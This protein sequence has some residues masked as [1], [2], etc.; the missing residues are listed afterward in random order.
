MGNQFLKYLLCFFTGIFYCLEIAAQELFPYAEAAS[1]L[2]KGVFSYR[3]STEYYKDLQNHSKNWYAVRAMYG[4]TKNF[5]AILTASGSN[6][7]IKNFPNGYAAYFL[8]HHTR[9][10]SLNAF[11]F[12]GF[13]LYLKYRVVHL[14]GYK[15]H[16]RLAVY[17]EGSNCRVAHD[18]A[19]PNLMGDNAGFG[20][21]AIA[22]ALYHRAALSITAGYVKP[23]GYYDQKSDVTF[24]SGNLFLTN[25]SL[26][27][28]LFPK[29]YKSYNDLNMSIYAELIY[30]NYQKATL[31]QAS[32]VFDVSNFNL[33]DPFTY[34]SLQ[35]NQYCD[36][37]TYFQWV[38]NAKSRIDI[39]V[40][41]QLWQKS[42]VHF[43]PMMAINYQRYIFGKTGK[44]IY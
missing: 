5:T 36:L 34:Q 39:G 2:P 7:H 19:E 10:N 20:G 13:H 28:L 12:E 21:G 26:G 9:Y 3:L 44:R 22:T 35:K 41:W 32:N 31:Q 23:I 40:S 4:V 14:D 27:Y 29:S 42:Y 8:N 30:R 38:F 37:R 15:K 6:H 25:L 33:G 18:E 16:L 1:T 24:T 17:A 11:S 43:Y